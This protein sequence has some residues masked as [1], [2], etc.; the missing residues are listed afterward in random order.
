M[1]FVLAWR[2]VALR[3]TAE[4]SPKTPIGEA[5][6]PEEV[7]YMKAQAKEMDLPMKNVKDA[8]YFISKLGGFTDRYERAGWQI[9]W[10]GWMKFYERVAGFT[11]AR[12]VSSG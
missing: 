2:I 9:L 4:I 12:K 3:T 8:I 11:L 7:D 5:F 10:Q 6:I 1:A